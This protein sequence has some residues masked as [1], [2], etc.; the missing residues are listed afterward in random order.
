MYKIKVHC[1]SYLISAIIIILLL[2]VLIIIIIAVTVKYQCTD[3]FLHMSDVK[4]T[5]DQ[6]NASLKRC[7]DKK[8]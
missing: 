4:C 2:F 6:A 1:I 3:W 5:H 8:L 7:D